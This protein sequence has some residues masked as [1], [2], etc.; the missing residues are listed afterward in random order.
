M[1]HDLPIIGILTRQDHSAAWPGYPLYGQGAAYSQSVALAGGAPV[2]IPLE[3]GE[4][5]W[6]S[7]YRRL[8]GLL[9]PGGVDVDPVH[10]GQARQPELGEVNDALDEA[11]LLLTRW[12]LGDDRPL[13]GI[14]R[15]IQLLNVAAGGSLYQD[16][17]TQ[18]PGVLQHRFSAPE[19][20]RDHLGHPVQV[21]ADSRLAEALGS[22]KGLGGFEM[23]VNSRHHQAIK[24]VAPGFV[25]TARAPDGVIEGIERPD[26]RFCIGVQWHP[27]SMAASDPQM[28]ALFEAFV[29]AAGQ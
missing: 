13:L 20:P 12:A 19:Y 24:D 23:Q 9:L 7:I 1:T 22:A 25:V 11:E 8:D 4:R 3:L 10:Y 21:R 6:R 15:G 17:P 18:L 14:C 16:L 27:E 28:L 5:A 29:R 2:L 26:A